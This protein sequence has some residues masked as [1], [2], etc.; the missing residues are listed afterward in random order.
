MPKPF[1]L[2]SRRP[3]S[4][5]VSIKNYHSHIWT[6][7]IL[8]SVQFLGVQSCLLLDSR[9]LDIQ[10]EQKL[11]IRAKRATFTKVQK[12]PSELLLGVQS[13]C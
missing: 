9:D 8:N 10:V 2:P 12:L 6:E 4:I 13:C 11:I 1:S 5:R 3:R 7:S